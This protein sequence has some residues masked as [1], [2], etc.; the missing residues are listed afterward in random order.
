MVGIDR[1]RVEFEQPFRQ[2]LSMLA[3]L[4]AIGVAAWFLHKPI[5]T[6]FLANVGLN[7][8]I[9][10]VFLIGLIATFWQVLALV[11]SVSWIEGF[12]IDRPGHEFVEPPGLLR[13]LSTLLRDQRARRA[14][15]AS[16]T[17][18]ILDTVATRIDDS[19]DI[20]RYIINLLIFLGLLGTFWGLSLTVPEVVNTIRSLKP[21]AGGGINFDQLMTGL[22][23]QLSGMGT[24]FASSLLGLAGS[25]VVGLL[26]L[27]A[28]RAQN[29]FF[30]ELEDWLASITRIS[31]TGDAAEGDQVGAA[32]ALVEQNSGQIGE[33]AALVEEM[34][35]RAEASEAARASSEKSSRAEFLEALREGAGADPGEAARQ[36]ALLARIAERLDEQGAAAPS[37]PEEETHARIRNI[38]RQLLRLLEDMAAGRQDTVSEIRAE[39]GGLSRALAQLAERAGRG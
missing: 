33:L 16:S 11:R 9:G 27:F 32:L 2:I 23:N 24:A 7:G 1:I 34:F 21:D 37:D 5:Q 15:T 20:T 18:S 3:A 4:A 12:A 30:R 26:E 22:E 10:C 39:I 8:L 25:L 19:R 36:T 13:S 35:T 29:Q 28:S 6:V 14:L 38:D 17:R 31:I